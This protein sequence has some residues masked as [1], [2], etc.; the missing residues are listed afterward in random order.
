M[1]PKEIVVDLEDK[2][3]EV[4]EGEFGIYLNK[5]LQAMANQ[6][7]QFINYIRDI[8]LYKKLGFDVKYFWDEEN[9][10]YIYKYYRKEKI[11]FR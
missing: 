5:T 7:Q 11:G 3:Q 10:K 2:L 8:Q 1:E 6:Q 4:S 9:Q